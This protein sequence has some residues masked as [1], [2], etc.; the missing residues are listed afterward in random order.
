[1]ASAVFKTVVSARKRRRVGSIPTRLRQAGTARW[2]ARPA[3]LVGKAFFGSWDEG[4]YFAGGSATA[5]DNR[6]MRKSILFLAIVLMAVC[7]YAGAP[8]KGV[9]VKLGKNPGGSP[10]ART[11]DANGHF[12]FGVVEKGSYELTLAPPASAKGTPETCLVEVNGQKAAWHFNKATDRSGA[13]QKISV[14]SDGRHPIHGV[15]WNR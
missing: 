2:R 3:A 10:A 14:T 8:L 6:R 5:C 7:A 11:T 15:V 13:P 4:D 12:D 1:V 9:D